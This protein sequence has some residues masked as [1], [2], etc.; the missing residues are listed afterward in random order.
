MQ[1][2]HSFDNYLGVLPY[3]PGT[4][5]HKGP[6]SADDHACVNGLDCARDPI[7]GNYQC[8]NSNREAGGNN[9]SAFHS[10]DFCVATDLNHEWI[11]T[12]R[13]SNFLHPNATFRSSPNNG[14]VRVND[15]S[16]QPD[17]G[18]ETP[19]DDET[20]SFCNEGDIAFYYAL[21]ETFAIDDRYFSPVLGPSFPNRSYLMAA[22]SFG[23]L[24]TDET[25]PSGAPFVVYHPLT[26]T[27]FDQLDAHSVSWADYFS[28]IPRG[29]S[30]RNF[31]LDPHF[32]LFQK[33]GPSALSNPAFPFN[34]ENSFF[35][36]AAAGTLPA[37]VLV[38]AAIG[39]FAPENDE[40]PGSDLR[41]GQ[42]LVAQIVNALRNTPNWKDSI[43]F[44][45]YDEHGGFYDHV[46]APRA[47]QGGALNPDGISPGQCA[48][49]SNPPVSSEPGGGLNCTESA[50]IESALCPG[51]APSGPFP[52]G[53]A[54]FDQ[55][56]MRVPLIA[57]SPFS[58]PHYV[59]HRRGDHTSL[60]ALIEKRFFADKA[61]LTARDANASTLEDLF[62]FDRAPSLGAEVS[63]ALAPL[64][65][66][67][68]AR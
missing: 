67:P 53:C 25:V 35:Q 27:I 15:R 37:V 46:G 58:K 6:C 44:I 59:S 26:C 5:Y 14:F 65:A 21:A 2:N 50:A 38:D 31:L 40:H 9:V 20:M 61:H 52:A 24:T 22:T 29:I 42:N 60:L 54:N 66:S 64:P 1:E 55:L 34:S 28:D 16:N 48:D 8:H 47:R 63:P 18:V 4:P 68:C 36:D 23:H 41:L 17:H 45:T 56:G 3:S 43:I 13:E 10:S 51:F 57:V 19:T 62:D 33:P 49:A 12:H 7:T 39:V 30:F 11:G 32:R